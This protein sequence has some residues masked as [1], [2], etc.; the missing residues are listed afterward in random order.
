MTWFF[1]QIV[2][3]ICENRV[4]ENENNIIRK[5]MQCKEC[6]VGGI[7]ERDKVE[8]QYTKRWC[9]SCQDSNDGWWNPNLEQI[10]IVGKIF[11]HVH[12]NVIYMCKKTSP[13]D[14][15]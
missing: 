11:M 15:N 8:L 1:V 3:R 10:R 4:Q 13:E 5:A 6:G 12:V 14:D 7:I 2:D 9:I